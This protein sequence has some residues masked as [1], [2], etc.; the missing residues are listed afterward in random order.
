MIIIDELLN[1]SPLLEYT[2]VTSDEKV[3]FFDIETTGFSALSTQLYLIGCV[4]LDDNEWKMRQWFVED[5]NEEKE[6]LKNFSTFLKNYTTVIH[7]NGDGFDIPYLN[8][9]YARYKLPSPFEGLRSIDIY[10]KLIPFKKFL[11]LESL[12]QKSIERFLSI[13]REDCFGGGELIYVYYEYL[14]KKEDMALKLLL[15]HNHD[16]VIGMLNLLPIL[17]YPA[18]KDTN[19]LSLANKEIINLT[20]YNDSSS[21]KLLLEFTTA[22]SFPVY[23]KYEMPYG[24][25]LTLESNKVKLLIPI[26]S[27]E[28]KYFYTN[29]KDYYYLPQEDTAIHKSVAQFVDK[30]YRTQAKACN[31]YTRK[32]SEYIPVPYKNTADLINTYSSLYNTDLYTFRRNHEDKEFF[33]EINSLIPIS[34]SEEFLS[35]LL[36]TYTKTLFSEIF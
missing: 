29:Y 18:L 4:Y 11:G 1:I 5:H 33:C 31:C 32:A 6:C 16:D 7:F 12:K 10:K 13:E 23:I 20:D 24:I 26:H 8:K 21:K 14:E 25:L 22:L 35:S 3:I 2:G 19:T 27:E 28:M 34:S 15:M 30:A 17:S 9:K 36:T